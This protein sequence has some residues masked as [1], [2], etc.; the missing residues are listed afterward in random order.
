MFEAGFLFASD[1]RPISSCKALKT[2]TPQSHF[3]IVG[4]RFGVFELR[5][6][7]HENQFLPTDSNRLSGTNDV[8][9]GQQL[10]R[11]NFKSTLRRAGIPNRFSNLR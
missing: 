5:G 2:F 3:S 7:D 10:I 11:S 1:P 8:G 6:R 4:H 9:F